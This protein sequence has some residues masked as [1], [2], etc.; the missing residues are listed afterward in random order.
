M[1]V[2]DIVLGIALAITIAMLPFIIIML[3]FCADDYIM[4]IGNEDD[5]D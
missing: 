4:G 3:A 1:S 5:V 2:I